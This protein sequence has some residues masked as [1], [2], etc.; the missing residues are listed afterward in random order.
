M[1]S[2]LLG[3]SQ[4]TDVIREALSE[5]IATADRLTTLVTADTPTLFPG[6]LLLSLTD[7][8]PDDVEH[9][10]AVDAAIG[11]EYAVLHQYIHAIPRAEEP[12]VSPAA[13][14]LYETDTTAAILDG[15]FLQSCAF[16]RLMA[17]VEDPALAESTLGWISR[18]ST[19]CYERTMASDISASSAVIAP[20]TGVAARVGASLGG[21]SRDQAK[22]AA[23]A[24]CS[25]TA[26]VPVQLPT[27]TTETVDISERKIDIRSLAGQITGGSD[28]AGRAEEACRTITA[29]VRDHQR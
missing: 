13:G 26:A 12:L 23:H 20:L 29:L 25:I 24:A 22:K 2:Q 4:F 6:R 21:G 16:S 14:S 7:Y 15:D 17:A 8:T 10:R 1:S 11:I 27:G 9:W 3:P 19:A 5:D 28:S 18:A